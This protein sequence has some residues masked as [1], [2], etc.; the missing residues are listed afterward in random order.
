M[1]EGTDQL[2][3][4]RLTGAFNRGNFFVFNFSNIQLNDLKQGEVVGMR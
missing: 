1:R 4:R 3:T 2:K